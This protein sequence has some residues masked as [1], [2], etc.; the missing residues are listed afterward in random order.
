[1]AI[2]PLASGA[3]GSVGGDPG[4]T[5]GP[6]PRATM[7]VTRCDRCRCVSRWDKWHKVTTVEVS[8]HRCRIITDRP[9]D[10]GGPYLSCTS[11]VPQPYLS[12]TSAALSRTSAVPQPYLSRTSVVSQRYLSRT[13]LYI[14]RT[15]AVPQPYISRTSPVPQPYLSRASAVHQPCSSRTTASLVVTAKYPHPQSSPVVTGYCLD[16]SG[17]SRQFRAT[18]SPGGSLSQT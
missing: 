2:G 16:Q 17:S 13:S 9:Q 10:Q 4:G 3:A 18:H 5:R 12:R 11:A 1:V 15:S 7:Y 6:A 8:G 14:G